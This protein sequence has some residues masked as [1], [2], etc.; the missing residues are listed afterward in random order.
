MAR[1]FTL[2]DRLG[3]V[4]LDMV[5]DAH[6]K[7]ETREVAAELYQIMTMAPHQPEAKVTHEPR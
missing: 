4:L 6:C 3:S 5:R 2:P 7:P 1:T